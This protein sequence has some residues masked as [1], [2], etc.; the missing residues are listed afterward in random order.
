MEQFLMHTNMNV[1][2]RILMMSARAGLACWFALGS[3]GGFF[4][5]VDNAGAQCDP[6]LTTLPF[7]TPT[8]AGAPGEISAM[9]V[10]D[11]SLIV[12]GNFTHAGGIPASNVAR[13]NGLN[14]QAMGQ[15]LDGLGIG[16]LQY[17]PVL[18]AGNDGFLYAT[19]RFNRPDGA[20][21]PLAR[22]DDSTWTF[23]SSLRGEALASEIY[24]AINGSIFL[25][26]VLRFE[27]S[28]VVN[29]SALVKFDGVTVDRIAANE[30][31]VNP[32]MATAVLGGVE[33][34]VVSGFPL[35]IP[36]I[37]SGGV[38]GQFLTGS[39]WSRFPPGLVGSGQDALSRVEIVGGE[40]Q[41]W[42]S[43]SFGSNTRLVSTPAGTRWEFIPGQSD[44]FG[45]FKTD[46]RSSGDERVLGG[47][48]IN[49]MGGFRTGVRSNDETAWRPLFDLGLDI[50]GV[51]FNRS[52]FCSSICQFYSSQIFALDFFAPN[53]SAQPPIVFAGKFD[54]IWPTTTIPNNLFGSSFTATTRLNSIGQFDGSTITPLGGAGGVGVTR[55]GVRSII[56][57]ET[58]FSMLVIGEFANANGLPNSNG[59][60]LYRNGSWSVPSQGIEGIPLTAAPSDGG[61]LLSGII[62]PRGTT[63][64]GRA[65]GIDRNNAV[66]GESMNN[67]PYR[68]VSGLIGVERVFRLIPGSRLVEERYSNG[69]YI[70]ISQLASG[71]INDIFIAPKLET[72]SV[73]TLYAWG[74]AGLWPQGQSVLRLTG[75]QW[76]PVGPSIA[77]VVQTTGSFIQTASIVPTQDGPRL[78]LFGNFL[79]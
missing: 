2:N 63:F 23:D 1:S 27:E 55:P 7:G 21:S 54:G 51:P 70:A 43:S 40:S 30:R 72:P 68:L 17:T 47:G 6:I 26:G 38:S 32:R 53:S 12:T 5:L 16:L 34:L 46:R 8:F 9:R 57:Q 15:G 33:T 44:R 71:S 4:M 14:W 22:W 20:S 41:I 13:W 11:G 49:E 29:K 10:I 25:C 19:G 48:N 31:T 69:S 65:V 56:Y 74:T 39:T 3:L 50:S 35:T 75:S 76:E 67:S 77:T 52:Q 24:P 61:F 73:N 60:L 78:V 64:A 45:V 59:A 42:S 66:F 62:R 18:P 79:S 58:P 37:T 28:G 36:G